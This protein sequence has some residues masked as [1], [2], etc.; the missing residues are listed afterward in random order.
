MRVIKTETIEILKHYRKLTKEAKGYV[1]ELEE[2]I[3]KGPHLDEINL[4]KA[5]ILVLNNS[6]LNLVKL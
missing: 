5:K 1:S 3:E 2:L 6:K 4:D